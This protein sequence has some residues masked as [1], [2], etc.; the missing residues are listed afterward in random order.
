M[1]GDDGMDTM[2]VP[3]LNQK[4]IAFLDANRHVIENE[5]VDEKLQNEYDAERLIQKH[6]KAVISVGSNL[7]S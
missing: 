4:H 7:L 6:K 5:E 1:Y 2:R 3:F